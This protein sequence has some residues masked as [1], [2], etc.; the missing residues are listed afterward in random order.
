[1]PQALAGSLT[2]RRVVTPTFFFWSKVPQNG[3]P[4]KSSFSLGV[5]VQDGSG[6]DILSE[7]AST[8]YYIFIYLVDVVLGQEMNVVCAAWCFERFELPVCMTCDQVRLHLHP[9][10]PWWTFLWRTEETR[11]AKTAK[12][13]KRKQ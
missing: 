10:H 2:S 1:M 13:A 4:T 6:L 8:N 7:P 9:P 12:A 11:R 3:S 5:G